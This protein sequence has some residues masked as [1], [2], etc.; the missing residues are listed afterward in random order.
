VNWIERLL[1]FLRPRPPAPKPPPVSV[2]PTADELLRWINAERVKNGRRPLAYRAKLQDFAAS[3]ARDMA[4]HEDPDHDA[5]LGDFRARM[6]RSGYRYAAAAENVGIYPD[7]R[8]A[9]IGWANSIIH[10][11]N[12]LSPE[13]TEFGGAV[14]M[15][16][17]GTPH[18]CACF[19]RPA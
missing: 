5:S 17:S 1:S 4:I 16:P 19:A 13:Y 12:L 11:Q 7:A 9:V 15:S 6:D 8:A 14:A 2:P 18:W 10:R 3:H